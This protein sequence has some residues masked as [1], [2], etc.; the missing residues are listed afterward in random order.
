MVHTFR[1]RVGENCSALEVAD[2]EVK[3]QPLLCKLLYKYL[4]LLSKVFM[5]YSH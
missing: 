3:K 5:Y 2:T 1:S 4:S